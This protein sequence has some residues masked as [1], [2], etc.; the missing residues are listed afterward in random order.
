MTNNDLIKFKTKYS[1][2]YSNGM[3]SISGFDHIE[4][5]RVP[6]RFIDEVL[7]AIPSAAQD[8]WKE[9]VYTLTNK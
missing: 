2:V 5:L 7:E 8:E 1:L 9:I 6:E 3:Y 4:T